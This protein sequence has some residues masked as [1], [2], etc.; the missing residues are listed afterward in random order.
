MDYNKY[1]MWGQQIRPN[2]VTSLVPKEICEVVEKT[3]L[4][5][6]QTLTSKCPHSALQKSNQKLKLDQVLKKVVEKLQHDV[7]QNCRIFT[8]KS[9][10]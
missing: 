8:S 2:V 4:P 7:G 5:F 10:R 9:C 6:S 3:I 1:K